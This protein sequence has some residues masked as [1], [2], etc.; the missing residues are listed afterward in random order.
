MEV[1]MCG[2]SFS[3]E[4]QTHA[5]ISQF[6]DPDRVAIIGATERKGS[7]GAAIVRN[8]LDGFD[9]EL[10]PV[11]PNVDDVFGVPAYNT[12]REAE[13]VDLAIVSVPPDSVLEV[14]EDCAVAG[15]TNIVVITAGFGE[16]SET[17]VDREVR[18]R[19][20]AAEFDLS[21]VGPNSLGVM[22]TP[23]GLNATFGPDQPL[24][25]NVSL[26]SQSGAFI[27]A[28]IDWASA[29]AIG[30]KD[31]VSL[32]NKAVLDE[33]DF[34][35]FWG[36]DPDT[37]VIVGYLEGIEDGREFIDT[38][39]EISDETPV[40]MIKTGR[41]DAGARAASS[42]TGAL[43]GSDRAYTAGFRQSGVLRMHSIEELFDA[44]HILAEQ[45]LPP[46]N[47]VAIVTNAGGPG[48]IAT[49]TV[50][51]SLLEMADFTETTDERLGETLPAGANAHNP[52]DILGDADVERFRTTIEIVLEDSNV[53]A[54]L[55]I[56]APTAVLEFDAI[57]EQFA[58]EF[59]STNIPVSTCFMGGD[60]VRKPRNRLMRCG[61]PSYFDPK[62]AVRALDT[63]AQYDQIRETTWGEPT[64]FEV[65][66]DRVATILEEAT[67]HPNNRLGVEAM[68]LLEAYGIPIPDYEIVDS[69]SDAQT[70]AERIGPPVAM[71]I[72]SPDVVHKTDIGAVAVDVE[73]DDVED[74]YEEII[75]RTRNYQPNAT[76]QGVQIQEL[77]DID[78]GVE[79]IVGMNRD[80]QFGPVLLFGLGGIFVEV[81]EDTTVRIA[82]ITRQEAEGML[83]DIRATSLLRGVRGRE[84]VDIDGIIESLQRLSQLV[85]DFP[86]ILELDINPLVALPENVQA[87]DLRATVDPNEL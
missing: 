50:G 59:D 78:S 3:P 16:M 70:A 26:L 35:Q 71:K 33:I 2:A 20:L 28:V 41:T 5:S 84:S 58:T 19:E 75:T 65:D 82:P 15:I 57:A 56:A 83:D 31:V 36:R 37:D 81:L 61:I 27:T 53:D 29:H 24:D 64:S 46:G 73:L 12:I 34:M 87:I 17:G 11:N 7:V 25:G 86:A 8:I 79:T 38:A 69:P 1:S 23:R 4:G 48:V 52:V 66:R 6:F 55:V 39:R 42:H 72:V 30:F 76:I 63:L 67:A 60:R 43:A 10:I 77:V 47:R 68:E 85:T 13:D 44:A 74:R 80:S 51:E 45:P 62:R 40:L 18:L 22:S 32:G 54:V 49:D 14:L 9:G 21:I